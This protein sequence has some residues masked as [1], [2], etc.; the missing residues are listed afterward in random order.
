[1]LAIFEDGKGL[2]EFMTN[3][4]YVWDRA[5]TAPSLSDIGKPNPEHK[6]VVISY[7]LYEES[8]D[9]S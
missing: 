8:K 3:P 1:M 6:Y 5:A 9:A 2:F 7:R 4:K